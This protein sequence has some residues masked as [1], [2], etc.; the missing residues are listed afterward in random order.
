MGGFETD[1]DYQPD[2][3]WADEFV[4]EE[5]EQLEYV[6]THPLVRSEIW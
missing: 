2:L 4:S 3:D 5:V 6:L 1:D